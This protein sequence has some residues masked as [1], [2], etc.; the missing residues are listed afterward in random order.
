MV[1]AP[2]RQDE[3]FAAAAQLV[4]F[5]E[6]MPT[7]YRESFDG[8][9]VRQ[10]ARIAHERAAEP[11]H[12]GRFSVDQPGGP[13]LCVVAMDAPGV[14]AAICASLMVEGFEVMQAEAFTRTNPAGESEAVDLFWVRRV[15]ADQRGPL[16]EDDALAIRA[17]LVPLLRG[18]VGMRRRTPKPHKA[19]PAAT[20]TALRFVE[21]EEAPWLTL[22]VHTNDRSGLLLAITS[23]LLQ[24]KIQITQARIRTDGT[25]V[26]DSFDLVQADGTQIPRRR[27]QRIQ[28]AVLAAIDGY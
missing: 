22:H 8:P 24:E 25:R 9:A 28:L 19:T 1:S 5:L 27:L 10:H 13:A 20:E 6:T 2:R 17:T 12:V 7:R 11:A 15:L 21:R 16:T 23:T 14:L 18:E 4:D 3:E 26:H